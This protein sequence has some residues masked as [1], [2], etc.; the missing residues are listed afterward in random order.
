MV[1]LL[2]SLTLKLIFLEVCFPSLRIVPS[3][4]RLW[5]LGKCV[6]WFISLIAFPL[7]SLRGSHSR[8]LMAIR[9]SSFDTLNPFVI[10]DDKPIFH[11][12]LAVDLNIRTCS[13]LKSVNLFEL[14]PLLKYLYSSVSDLLPSA[15]E[16]SQKDLIIKSSCSGMIWDSG[17]VARAMRYVCKLKPDH[18]GFSKEEQEFNYFKSFAGSSSTN[19][20]Y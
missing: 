19:S 7:V 10:N 14:I 3:S 13:G 11:L 9:L 20:S 12:G 18:I 2:Q 1:P 15:R 8:C 5:L 17:L 6:A 16:F 4:S